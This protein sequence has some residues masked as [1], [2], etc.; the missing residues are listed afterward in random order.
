MAQTEVTVNSGEAH[1]IKW[2]IYMV[3][4]TA[5]RYTMRFS[6][7]GLGADYNSPP[8]FK[9]QM[10]A[11]MHAA[12]RAKEARAEADAR[13]LEVYVDDDAAN[14]AA[15]EADAAG[16]GLAD[17][18]DEG[19]L[20][21]S[22]E[23]GAGRLPADEVVMSQIDLQLLDLV[24]GVEVE[25]NG[26]QLALREEANRAGDKLGTF[27]VEM[28]DQITGEAPGPSFGGYLDKAQ[29]V[30]EAHAWA[31]SHPSPG[32]M[33]EAAGEAGEAPGLAPAWPEPAAVEA[34]EP[35]EVA[36]AGEPATPVEVPAVAT[37]HD[38]P[39]VEAPVADRP[40]KIDSVRV[41]TSPAP[42]STPRPQASE[43]L[44]SDL[45]ELA[46]ERLDKVGEKARLERG[47]A[48]GKARIKS[49]DT[50]IAEI[51]ARSGDLVSRKA[52]GQRPLPL[53]TPAILA[54][55]EGD[56]PAPR[57]ADIDDSAP[58]WS[59]GPPIR[60]E[61]MIDGESWPVLVRERAPDRFVAEV[62]GVVDSEGAGPTFDAAVTHA[63]ER[64]SIHLA[65]R[66][67]VPEAPAVVEP[68]T[69]PKGRRKRGSKPAPRVEEIKAAT[70]AKPVESSTPAPAP[71]A[72]RGRK[73][74]LKTPAG[75]VKFAA[76]IKA[77]RESADGVSA[78]AGLGVELYVLRKY[79]DDCGAAWDSHV[80]AEHGGK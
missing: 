6:D 35:V 63:V 1:G 8:D 55:L 40:A 65:D 78:A 49:L 18:I 57:R 26:W 59:P 47:I 42:T 22:I 45:W 64:A 19:A 2:E 67:P 9:N 75:G 14:D 33:I 27:G 34:P 17:D 53:S 37:H 25:I 3:T 4:P 31:S 41:T 7:A 56:S 28:Y 74:D 13:A 68:P 43:D 16:L 73:P 20:I 30:R 70:E 46:L 60:L 51:D 52:T 44:R 38:D 62:V 5:F 58:A 39:I 69:A 21:R 10:R 71:T 48:S 77:I 54:T 79:V 72:K 29:A 50:E 24:Q 80:G 12:A 15:D 32:K 23:V 11:D 76:V 61:R 66:R 36:P